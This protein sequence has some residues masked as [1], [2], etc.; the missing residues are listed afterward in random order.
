MKLVS[1]NIGLAMVSLVAISVFGTYAVLQETQIQP[2]SIG[3]AS[4]IQGHVTL[5]QYD[6]EGNIKAYRQA[7]NAIVQNG[8]DILADRLFASVTG[9][10][11]TSTNEALAITEMAVGTSG[12][13]PAWNDVNVTEFGG[14]NMQAAAFTSN[15]A[16]DSGSSNATVTV[17]GVATFSGATCNAILQEAGMFNDWSATDLNM[18]AR[19]TYTSVDVQPADSLEL[20]WDFTFT[21]T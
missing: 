16:R 1:W 15:G 18:F 12:T 5:I 20:T 17:S 19:N 11:S 7:D 13:A 4:A 6:D 8:M 10:N 21:D 9:G 3:T 14:C 2:S